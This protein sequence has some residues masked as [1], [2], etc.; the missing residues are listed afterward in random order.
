M[1]HHAEPQPR[2]ENGYG[3]PEARALLLTSRPA[4][5]HKHPPA[6]PAGVIP[7]LQEWEPWSEMEPQLQAS[8][9]SMGYFLYHP[10]QELIPHLHDSALP[11]QH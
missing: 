8:C 4:I 11:A 5:T 9:S 1:A 2:E 10:D 3:L 7:A 6:P